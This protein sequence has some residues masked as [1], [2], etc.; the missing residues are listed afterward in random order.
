[1]DRLPGNL[2]LNFPTQPVWGSDHHQAGGSMARFGDGEFW[3]MD[4]GFIT[5]V[6]RNRMLQDFPTCWRD[7]VLVEKMAKNGEKEVYFSFAIRKGRR[8]SK[9]DRSIFFRTFTTSNEKN[10]ACSIGMIKQAFRC[11]FIPLK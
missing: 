8:S 1:M 3:S 4:R 2:H 5:P 7:D 10:H 9:F 6:V 11:S